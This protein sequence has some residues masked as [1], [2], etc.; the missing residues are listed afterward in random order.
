MILRHLEYLVAL[1]R[2]RHFGRAAAACGVT[3]PTLSA[4]IRELETELDVLIVERGQRFRGLTSE[5]E[6][7]VEWAR[8]ILA[9][10]DALRQEVGSAKQDLAGRL[11]IGAIPTALASVGLLTAP[12][13]AQHPRVRIKLLSL[14]SI[15]IQR[16]LDNFDLDAGVTYLDNEPLLRVRAVPLYRERYFLVTGDRSLF[17]RR[18]SV[19]WAEASEVPLCLLTPDMQNRRIVDAIFHEAGHATVPRV[20]TN[21]ILGIYAHIRGDG[22]A[23]ILTQAALYLLGMPRWLRA[24]PLDAPAARQTIGL[25]HPEREPQQPV[26]RAF[27]ECVGALDVD[28]EMERNLPPALRTPRDR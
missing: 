27:V 3:Q 4:A 12:F 11:I 6:R 5:G 20:E 13:Q 9:D 23:S 15:E 28:S 8:R 18:D 17:R 24:L 22:M 14:S 1:A 25:V 16:A 7:V 10:R 2:E 21:S 26:A 19:T